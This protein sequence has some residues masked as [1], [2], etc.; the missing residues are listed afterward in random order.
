LRVTT[1][2]DRSRT[3]ILDDSGPAGGRD[4]A[5]RYEGG[6]VDGRDDY[7]G[8]RDAASYKSTTT[9]ASKPLRPA[10]FFSTQ[11]LV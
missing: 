8:N 9:P 7:S 1:F 10:T 6:N 5:G 11:G 2:F 4:S 3:A